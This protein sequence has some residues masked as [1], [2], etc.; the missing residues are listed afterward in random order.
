MSAWDPLAAFEANAWS[1]VDFWQVP[2]SLT[3]CWWEPESSFSPFITGLKADD[4]LEN[5]GD[6][7]T[8]KTWKKVYIGKIKTD[9]EI[10]AQIP[11]HKAFSTHHPWFQ[12][13]RNTCQSFHTKWENYS[14]LYFA[15]LNTFI[16]RI[17]L[18]P[19]TLFWYAAFSSSSFH[20]QSPFSALRNLGWGLGKLFTI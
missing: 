9:K 12:K 20:W 19:A 13:A 15:A 4:I 7:R 8:P 16:H 10:L 5:S 3:K 11:I 6:S 1:K 2:F 17:P 14:L 18:T